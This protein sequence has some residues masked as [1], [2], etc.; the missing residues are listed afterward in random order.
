M[1]R[2]RQMVFFLG[3]LSLAVSFGC[4]SKS[5]ATTGKPTIPKPSMVF[6]S[7]TLR[8]LVAEARGEKLPWYADRKDQRRS[9]LAGSR[10]PIYERAV[11]VT[12]DQQR[13]HGNRIHD[14]YN[15]V[16]YRQRVIEITR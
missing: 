2:I 16:T 7:L 4:Q 3:V 14:D 13:S 1:R 8:S 5:Q 15:S 12:I 9:V 11:N 10:S 6:D